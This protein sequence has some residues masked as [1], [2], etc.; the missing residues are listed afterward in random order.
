MSRGGRDSI[1]IPDDL[2]TGSLGSDFSG[3][4]VEAV[5]PMRMYGAG[6]CKLCRVS[7]VSV[8]SHTCF[9]GAVDA[10]VIILSRECSTLK[11]LRLQAYDCKHITRSHTIA[12]AYA[13][14]CIYKHLAPACTHPYTKNIE[15]HYLMHDTDLIADTGHSASYRHPCTSGFK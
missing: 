12:S 15:E 6:C 9:L 8:V 7:L 3:V 11:V 10:L 14:T 5:D 1:H 13:L 2:E 4:E